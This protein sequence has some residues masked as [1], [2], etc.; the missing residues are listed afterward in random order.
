MAGALSR[1]DSLS[2]CGRYSLSDRLSLADSLSGSF[3]LSDRLS[4]S[5]TDSLW[6]TLWDRLPLSLFGRLSLADFN[7]WGYL[8]KETLKRIT[9]LTAGNI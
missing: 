4:L 5:R 2:L 1:A 3:S 9:G 6:Q 8:K 7:R